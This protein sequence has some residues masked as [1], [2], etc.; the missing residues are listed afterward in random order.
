M[1]ILPIGNNLYINNNYPVKNKLQSTNLLQQRDTFEISFKGDMSYLNEIKD[2]SGIHCPTC[3]AKMLSQESYDLLVERASRIDSTVEFVKLLQEYKDFVPR[4]MRSILRGVESPESFAGVEFRDYFV[5][6]AKHANYRHRR[7]ITIANAFLTNL[8]EKLPPEQKEQLQSAISEIT[9]LEKSYFYRGK[10]YPL[11]KSFDKFTQDDLFN[12]SKSAFS[13][14]RNSCD[15]L[16]VFRIKDSAQ[17]TPSQLSE[18]VVRR[19]FGYSVVNH[20]KI[21]DTLP[22]DWINNE[23]L[24]CKRCNDVSTKN[25]FLGYNSLDDVEFEMNLR[26]Y[27]TDIAHLMGQGKLSYNRGY[28]TNMCNIVSKFSKQ[29]INLTDADIQNIM[30]ISYLATRHDIFAPA[31]QTKMDVPCA[32]CGSDMLPH[33]VKKDIDKALV[34]CKKTKDYV[35]VLAR[36]DK[37]LGIYA[38]DTAEVIYNLYNKSPDLPVKEFYNQVL[39]GVKLILN[40]ETDYVLKKYAKGRPYLLHNG[41]LKQLETMDYILKQV[42]N[43]VKS[44]KFNDFNYKNMVAEC[45]ANVDLD[46]DCTKSTYI[47]LEDMKKIAYKYSLTQPNFHSLKTDQNVLHTLVFNLF[48]SDVLTA[49]HLDAMALGGDKSIYNMVGLCKG[50]NTL[51]G[52][53]SINSWFSQIL[54]VRKNFDKHLM[55]VDQMAKDGI[56]S[57]FDD[58]AKIIAQRVYEATHNKF[59]MRY[60]F[61]ETEDI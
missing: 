46:N 20:T 59:D 45:F 52:R 58:W 26:S 19:L 32:G 55:V 44:G 13:Y 43:Y 36:Y 22:E 47:F 5:N 39:D 24:M 1:K 34:H 4:N 16:N 50:C 9:P 49:D 40:S 27:L 41:T 57:G 7:H 8:S 21:S 42:T 61:D 53:K 11:I 29:K 48:K 38:K 3:G 28:I 25:I 56:I 15:Y 37:Y 6:A 12:A 60:L 10:L 2:Y 18:E 23:V 51:K 54:D 14:V 31:S 35:D 30:R 17:L 33:D